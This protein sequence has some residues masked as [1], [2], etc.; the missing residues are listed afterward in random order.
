MTRLFNKGTIH[1]VQYGA[2]SDETYRIERKG[3]GIVK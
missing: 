3:L 1:A 2:P